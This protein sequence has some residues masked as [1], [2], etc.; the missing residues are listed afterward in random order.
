LQRLA[1]LPVGPG[2]AETQ[3]ASALVLLPLAQAP[4]GFRLACS[5]GAMRL[6]PSDSADASASE[7]FATVMARPTSAGSGWWLV[8]SCDG[9]TINGVVPLPL[10]A[11]EAGDLLAVGS[12]WWLVVS[13]WT[14]EPAPA[15][16]E[17]ADKPCPVCGGTLR[18][19]PVCRCRCGRYYH[20]EAPQNPD[21]GQALNCYLAGPCGLCSR[22]PSLEPM[23]SPE[24]PA[25]LLNQE[26][27]S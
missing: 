21:D 17:L 8:P 27:T 22:P 4:H 5:N 20:L 15:P 9:L 14:A 7:A 12:D 24:P 3:P 18:L 1:L 19:A 23:L 11:L 2:A 13:Q 25:K 26:T 6:V 10:S 16:A